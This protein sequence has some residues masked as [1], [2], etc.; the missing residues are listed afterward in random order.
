MDIMSNSYPGYLTY[1]Y[2]WENMENS[3]FSPSEIHSL[4][5]ALARYN[6]KYLFQR[7]MSVLD[8]SIPEE[9]DHGFFM[10]TL[11]GIGWVIILNTD[12]FGIIP[13]F[14]NLSGFDLYYNPAWAEVVNPVFNLDGIGN[15]YNRLRIGEDCT[16]LRLGTAYRGIGDIC[17]H[18][19]AQLANA[20]TSLNVNLFNTRFAYIFAAK[21]KA[22]AETLKRIYDDI[23]SGKPAVF[24]DRKLLDENG[25]LSVQMLSQDVRNVY[26]AGDLLNDMRT[27]LNN[28]DSM[29]G[30][31]NT[32]YSKKER[33]ITDEAN[34]NNFE[35]RALCYT[36]MDV[37]KQDIKKAN[38]MYGLDLSVD[39]RKEVSG[40]AQSGD[41]SA[42]TVSD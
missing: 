19:A 17:A 3:G 41:N 31:P 29:I 30:I 11:Y 27:I 14:G 36:W 33:L 34:M 2:G 26:I 5:N 39:F 18:Y 20:E 4:D 8:F 12:E 24:T 32:N 37:L 10:R 13:Q 15:K 21:N 22:Q 9:W 25:K 38:S 16:L 40:N 42:D 6:F 28:F 7:A 35:T 1:A 23:A